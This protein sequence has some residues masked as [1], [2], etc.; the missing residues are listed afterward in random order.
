MK[1]KGLP[2]DEYGV[3]VWIKSDPTGESMHAALSTTGATASAQNAAG[4]A[5]LKNA[6][7]RGIKYL[8][9]GSRGTGQGTNNYVV[10]DDSLIDI[11]RKYGIA[12][13]AAL[14]GARSQP[15]EQK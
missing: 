8:D 1:A 2:L 7:V 12:L 13:G 10:F 4:T 15:Q 9:Q 6:G 3:P 11:L 14:Q 5:L